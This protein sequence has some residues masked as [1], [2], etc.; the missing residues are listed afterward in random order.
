MNI[1]DV[2]DQKEKET[3][4]RLEDSPLTKFQN[5]IKELSIVRTQ[6]A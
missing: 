6:D 3:R 1:E 5:L 2:L 4:E